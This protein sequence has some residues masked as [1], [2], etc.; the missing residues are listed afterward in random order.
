MKMFRNMGALLLIAAI[1]FGYFAYQDIQQPLP[2]PVRL[3]PILP[4]GFSGQAEFH[5]ASE[6]KLGGVR[7]GGK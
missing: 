5:G 4:E 7:E 6:V 3:G 1:Q 2:E